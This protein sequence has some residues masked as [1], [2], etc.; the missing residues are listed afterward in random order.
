MS[1][2]FEALTFGLFFNEDVVVTVNIDATSQMEGNDSIGSSP[3]SFH[4]FETDS[5]YDVSTPTV[6]GSNGAYAA[7]FTVPEKFIGNISMYAEDN[8]AYGSN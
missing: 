8:I 2:A 6:T 1:R 7:S 5:S 4:V 3:V